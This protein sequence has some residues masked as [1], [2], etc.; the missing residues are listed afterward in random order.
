M[1]WAIVLMHLMGNPAMPT[2]EPVFTT[3]AACQERTREMNAGPVRLWSYVCERA[4][5]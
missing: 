5:R 4:E 2:S 3:Q 1:T